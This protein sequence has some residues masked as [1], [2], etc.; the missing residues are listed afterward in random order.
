MDSSDHGVYHFQLPIHL[1]GNL[2]GALV[3]ALIEDKV[4]HTGYLLNNKREQNKIADIE[5][6]YRISFR[7]YG[8]VYNIFFYQESGEW[9]SIATYYE[10]VRKNQ[11]R[12][13]VLTVDDSKFLATGDSGE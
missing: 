12:E 6:I 3:N 7:K 8:A 11:N 10:G 9:R 5:G 2:N 13:I 4:I 1:L